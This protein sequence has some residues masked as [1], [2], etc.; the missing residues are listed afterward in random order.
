MSPSGS[1]VRAEIILVSKCYCLSDSGSQFTSFTTERVGVIERKAVLFTVWPSLGS[2][3][4]HLD[5][6]SLWVTK[7]RYQTALIDAAQ[8]GCNV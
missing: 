6:T 2:Q 1:A 4:K 8:T 5:D 3:C 7:G